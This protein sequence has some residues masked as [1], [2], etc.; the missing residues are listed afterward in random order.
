MRLSI[1]IHATAANAS[2]VDYARSL[3]DQLLEAAEGLST[4]GDVYLKLRDLTKNNP[5][6]PLRELDGG[7]VELRQLDRDTDQEIPFLTVHT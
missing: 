4:P 2:E 3:R 6:M 5:R 1:T 7:R